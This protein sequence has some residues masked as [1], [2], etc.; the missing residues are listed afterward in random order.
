MNTYHPKLKTKTK[1]KT[2]KKKKGKRK[3]KTSEEIFYSDNSLSQAKT[4]VWI[5]VPPTAPFNSSH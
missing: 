2:K 3:R 1:M 4:S 5:L